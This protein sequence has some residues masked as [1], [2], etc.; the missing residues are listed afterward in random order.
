MSARRQRGFALLLMLAVLLIAGA[1]VFLSVQGGSAE[2]RAQKTVTD[3]HALSVARAALIMYAF[4]EGTNNYPGALPG[5]DTDGNGSADNNMECQGKDVC[6][7][8]FPYGTF[9]VDTRAYEDVEI[10]YA[11][12]GDYLNLGPINAGAP[13]DLSTAHGDSH[14]AVLVLAGEPVTSEQRERPSD[15]NEPAHYLEAE[16]ADGDLQF[17]SCADDR[18][19]DRVLGI[20][21]DELFELVQHRV[22]EAVR[23]ALEA[24]FSDHA[25]LPQALPFDADDCD[26]PSEQEGR[27]PIDYGGEYGDDCGPGE[28]IAEDRFA[29]WILENRW[30]DHIVYRVAESCNSP[31]CMT[32]NLSITTKDDETGEETTLTDLT[33]IVAIAGTPMDPQDRADS[34]E[35]DDYLE[36]AENRDGNKHYRDASLVEDSNDLFGWQ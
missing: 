20:T 3:A 31:P 1:A 14:A 7:G 4:Q 33:V 5:P 25:H 21:G 13:A 15:S 36:G 32:G 12:D 24:Y 10:W 9:D 26:E 19:N 29:E 2:R 18:C 22:L 34:P 8:R 11:L 28:W 30:A 16:N 17:E 23:E 35:V 27:L 6:L